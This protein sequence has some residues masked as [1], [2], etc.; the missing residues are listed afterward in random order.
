[1]S[2]RQ[3]LYPTQ[4][5]FVQLRCP[6]PTD[7]LC[8]R[9]SP[10]RLRPAAGGATLAASQQAWRGMNVVILLVTMTVGRGMQAPGLSSGN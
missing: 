3:F 1:M 2:Q 4:Q 10:A 5:K 9:L 8:S 6:L 7:F